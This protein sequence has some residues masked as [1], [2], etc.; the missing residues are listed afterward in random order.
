MTGTTQPWGSHAGERCSGVRVYVCMHAEVEYRVSLCRQWKGRHSGAC[1]CDD[2]SG[3]MMSRSM[4]AYVCWC[5][6]VCG[7]S[8]RGRGRH[9]GCG[10][11]CAYERGTQDGERTRSGARE[12][13]KDVA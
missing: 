2:S 3:S 12:L 5:V 9:C 13:R 8:V 1:E 4:C 6:H 11:G 7:R 10:G